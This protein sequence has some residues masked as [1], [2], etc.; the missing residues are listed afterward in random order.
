MPFNLTFKFNSFIGEIC[1]FFK[2]DDE[3]SACG[4]YVW[5][6]ANTFQIM[7]L[8]LTVKS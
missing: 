7:N 1:Q 2:T 5:C 4:K 8:G 3:A 6:V